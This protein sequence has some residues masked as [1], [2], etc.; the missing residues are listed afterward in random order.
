MKRTIISGFSLFLLVLSFFINGILFRASLYYYRLYLK[1]SLDPLGDDS[2]SSLVRESK[3]FRTPR[4]IFLGD[5]RARYWPPPSSL[6]STFL[7]DNYA[8]SGFTTSQVLAHFNRLSLALSPRD[9][10]V[11]QVGINDLKT[12]PFFLSD[13]D[14]ITKLC[15]ENISRLTSLIRDSGATVVLTTII[16]TGTIP[17]Y[18]RPIWPSSVEAS[19]SQCNSEIKQLASDSVY[20]LDTSMLTDN[21]GRIPSELQRNFLHI[22]SPAY[23]LLNTKLSSILSSIPSQ[24]SHS[25]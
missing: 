11:I 17:F 1:S 23:H 25:N 19:L 7:Y 3:V 8:V 4:I 20:I 16:P 24:R 18:R 2:T 9:I 22:S 15:S 5:S 13:R 14:R 21:S 12:I 6:R 10:V